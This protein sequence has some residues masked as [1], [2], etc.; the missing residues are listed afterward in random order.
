MSRYLERMAK[1]ERTARLRMRWARLAGM[2]IALS[3]ATALVATQWAY[4]MR[5]WAVH[6]DRA[7]DLES[8]RPAVHAGMVYVM[9][10]E[11]SPHN[12]VDSFPMDPADNIGSIFRCFDEL[13]Y[14]QGYCAVPSGGLDRGTHM[15]LTRRGPQDAGVYVVGQRW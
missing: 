1:I 15:V 3:L 10:G 7:A 14:Q 2:A 6:T 13:A 9:R 12:I 8:Y 4:L 11:Y 5:G